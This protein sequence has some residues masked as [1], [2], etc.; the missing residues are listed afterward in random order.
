MRKW[1]GNSIVKKILIPMLLVML[2]QSGLF[3]GTILWGGTIDQLNDNSYAIFNERTAGRKNYMQNE[4]IQ[5][6][7]N[8]ED[9]AKKITALAEPY[10]GDAGVVQT[11][12]PASPT[13]QLLTAIAPEV[14][15]IIRRNSVTGAFVILNGDGNPE[16]DGVYIR[17]LDP[18]SAPTDN[19]DL[20]IERAPTR[21]ARDMGITMD[22]WWNPKFTIGEKELYYMNP[23]EQ[24]VKRPEVGIVDLGYWSQ[25]FSLSGEDQPVITYSLPLRDSSGTVYGV[26]GVEVSLDYLRTLLPYQELDSSKEGS[27]VLAVDSTGNGDFTGV[28]AVGPAFKKLYG[29]NL[30]LQLQADDG[31][32]NLYHITTG[33]RA[34]Q[35]VCANVQYFRL[36]NTNTPFEGDRW[37]LI[38]VMEQSNLIGFSKATQ[39]TVM[40]TLVVSL[41]VGL[42]VIII[43]SRLITRPITSLARRVKGIDP[44]QP[45]SFEG[46]N[47]LEIDELAAAIANMSKNVADVSSK[48]T[49][50]IK[51]ANIPIG[52]FEFYRDSSQIFYTGEFFEVLGIKGDYA[53]GYMPKNEFKQILE[54]YNQRYYQ[55]SNEERSAQLYHFCGDQGDDRW[56]S[57]RII[58]D[59]QRVL[60]VAVDVTQ[61]TM[62]KR[63]IEYERDYDL[64]TNLLNRRAFQAQLKEKFAH[65]DQ[66]KTAAFVMFDL[67][68]LKF[69]N[70]SYGHDY[71]DEY[72]R[73]M[74][75]ELKHF[76]PFRGLVARMSG[77]EFYV[78][79]YGY[80]GKEEI[81]R[82]IRDVREGISRVNLALPDKQ[83]LKIRASAGVS[84]Y[85]D[86]STAYD[87][88][89][90]YADFAM[91]QVKNT[92]KGEV[93]EFCEADYQRDSFLL[94]S[95][96][97]F[98]RL[99]DEQ[100]VSYIFQPIVDV[101]T[102]DIYA[103]EA[104]MRPQTPGLK[105]P[106]E[107]MAMARSQS[108]LYQVERMTL[109]R[110]LEDFSRYDAS[111][112]ER[113]LFINSI[114]NQTLEEEDVEALEERYPNLLGRVVVELTED[115][116]HSEAMTVRKLAIIDRWRALMALDDYGSGYNGD[117][118]LL[119]FRPNFVKID[120]SLVRGIDQ[121]E[122]RQE[123]FR[124]MVSYSRQRGIRVIAE[125]VET[126][127]EMRTLVRLG[128]DYIQGFYFGK[129]TEVP[130]DAISL[131]KKEA[132]RRAMQDAGAPIL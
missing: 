118:M 72:I 103:Y 112:G 69:I 27:Y 29:D 129:G 35:Q 31:E 98:N 22:T 44:R 93:Q 109:F 61:E 36:Y 26:M 125:G 1:K 6:W 4:M 40:I 73:C 95:K 21:V 115:E 2:L 113:K 80:G 108:K 46:T 120:M 68:N 77:D 39:K 14:I 65:P 111:T 88:L 60:G 86:D 128:V 64:L 55:D 20:L 25:S 96:E 30:S 23:Y 83:L 130:M 37:A 91:Y 114:P 3:A 34:N 124:N 131:Q 54:Q 56:I 107:V 116:K 51:M 110:S 10:L 70:D 48:L 5:H 87:E 102:G 84:W 24:A 81:R 62:E 42:A 97:E 53:S 99:L 33:N 47:I 58:E 52:A 127:A 17:D 71:G 41:L 101:R 18:A 12:D 123:I 66:L 13:E 32:K 15:E 117:A 94:R 43:V 11:S 82:V 38:G 9:Y 19:S 57:L 90:R 76:I 92:C 63:K 74:A 85:P 45:V 79:L 132:L 59:K 106:S 8:L 49:Q 100:L 121:D 89:I 16:K 28:L 75:D 104:L 7:S 50:I 119:T 126:E 78:F 122:N 67:D 105:M